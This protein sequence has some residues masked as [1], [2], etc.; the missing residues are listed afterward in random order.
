[1]KKIIIL[2][3]FLIGICY[4]IPVKAEEIVENRDK[5]IKIMIIVLVIIFVLFI[6]IT[7]FYCIKIVRSKHKTSNVGSKN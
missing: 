4:F 3:S 2:F 6:G 5:Q 1:M 7:I